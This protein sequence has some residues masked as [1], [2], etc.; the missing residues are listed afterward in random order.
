MAPELTAMGVTTTCTD[1]Y[2]FGAF[3]L[4]V[5][6]GR[7][8]VDPDAPREQVIL[9]KWVASCGKRDALTDTV[10]SKLIDFKVEE[11]KLLL[12]L[13]MLCSQINPENRPSMRQILQYLEG[14]VSVPAISFGT[15]ALG[16]PNISH[17]TVTQMTTTSSSANFSFEDVTVLFGGR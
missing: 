8:P 15:V 10:D 2:A 7:R 1:V 14:N 9:V 6:C 13:G 5:V 17:E 4:E 12:K 16:I 3:I 11:A